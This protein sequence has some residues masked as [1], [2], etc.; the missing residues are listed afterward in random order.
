MANKRRRA[1]ERKQATLTARAL[2]KSYGDLVALAPLD[3]DVP[4]SQA[5]ALVGH[6][7]SGKSTLLQLAAGLLDPTDGSVSVQGHGAGSLAARAS[8]AYIGDSPVLYD[9]LSVW[10][11]LEYLGRI[12]GVNDWE[13]RSRRLL[14][15]LELA[16]RAD[17]L[18]VGFSRGLRQKTALAIGLVWDAPVILIDEP[19]VGLD[20]S[21]KTALLELIEERRARG[22]TIVLATHDPEVLTRVD[23]CI[24]LREGEVVHDGSPASVSRP[25]GL[26]DSRQARRDQLDL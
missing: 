25:D 22:A 5:V 3:L 6:N 26:F 21:G 19:F 11:H 23:R 18:P 2:T 24:E 20:A 10:E 7:G 1:P 9:D 4:R 13:E 17:D 12:R 14:E 8:L 15:R 16:Q